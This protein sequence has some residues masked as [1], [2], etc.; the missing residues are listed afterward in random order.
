MEIQL[1]NFMHVLVGFAYSRTFKRSFN[2]KSVTP[3]RRTYDI[4]AF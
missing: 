2:G 4:C 1:Y 3:E